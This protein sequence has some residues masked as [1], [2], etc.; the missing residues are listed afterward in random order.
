M[1]T[2][3][4]KA[5]KEKT[6]LHKLRILAEQKVREVTAKADE[7]QMLIEQLNNALGKAPRPSPLDQVREL[8]Q[9]T[10]DLRVANGNV[11]AKAIADTFG[12]SMNQLADWLGRSRQALAKT[13]A[14]DSLQ[15]E[16]AFFERVARL[17]AVMPKERFQKWLRMPHHQLDGKSPLELLASGEGQVVADFVDDMLT[18]APA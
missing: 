5:T 17:R 4:F 12:L 13:P 6:D 14:A 7:L 11:S 9:A 15:S 8:V 16:L 1:A 10:E 18:G 3:V 2:A